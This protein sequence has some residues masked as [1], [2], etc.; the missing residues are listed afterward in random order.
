[1]AE[2]WAA[3]LARPGG[4][5]TGLTVTHPELIEKKLELLK[6]LIPGLSRIAVIW[7]PSAI[8][9][10]VRAAQ[11]TGLVTAARS[12][13]VDVKIIEVRGPADFDPAFQQA[14]QHRRQCSLQPSW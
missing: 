1:M 9:P 2:G 10:S 14:I 4:N 7:D 12:L 6:E 5:V 3:S 13:R 8:P 11:T